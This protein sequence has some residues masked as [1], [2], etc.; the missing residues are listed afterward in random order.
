MKYTI[1]LALAGMACSCNPILTLQTTAFQTTNKDSASAHPPITDSS[2]YILL[3]STDHTVI[4]AEPIGNVT[5]DQTGSS[6]PWSYD[7]IASW[8]RGTA[9]ENGA[10]LVKITDFTPYHRRGLAHVNATLYRVP[11]LQPYERTIAWSSTRKL[12]Y[13]DFKGAPSPTAA[14]GSRCQFYLTTLFFCRESWIDAAAPDA[15]RLLEHEQGNFDLAELYRRQ[16]DAA[17]QGIPLYSKRREP[18]FQTIYGAYEAKKRQ[19]ARDTHHGSDSEKQ[20]VWTRQIRQALANNTGVPDPVFAVEPIFSMRQKDSAAK[21]LAPTAG[22]AL[23]YVIRPNNVS[24]SPFMRVVYDPIYLCC[25]YCIGMNVNVYT[26]TIQD[27]TIGPIKGH[28]YG[29]L[30]VDAGDVNTSTGMNMDPQFEGLFFAKAKKSTNLTI[31]FQPGKVYYFK[32]V[33]KAAWFGYAAP[34]LQLVAE[35]EGRRL[36]RKCK[37]SAIY[38]EPHYGLYAAENGLY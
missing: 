13:A 20:A 37:L 35:A 10:N 22:K 27:T 32:L 26:A 4:T 17:L 12:T 28:S 2:D 19:Y 11:Y 38:S 8:I 24:T 16:L 5:Y 25:I 36:L 3:P 7:K 33:T 6:I 18:I 34:E 23:V 14:S 29:Y 31:N 21:A 1:C 15:A 30:F 9:M